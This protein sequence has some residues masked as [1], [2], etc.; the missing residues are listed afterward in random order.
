MQWSLQ[1]HPFLWIIYLKS[2]SEDNLLNISLYA[3]FVFLAKLEEVNQI[4]KLPVQS[5]AGQSHGCGEF[6]FLFDGLND[7]ISSV[8]SHAPDES[9]FRWRP[10]RMDSI[11]L[12]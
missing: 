2:G 12:S 11:G 4:L 7:H 9:H 6:S 3:A 8:I 10:A 5:W 1:H